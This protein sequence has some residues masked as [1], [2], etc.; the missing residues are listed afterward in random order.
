MSSPTLA[1][2]DLTDLD[3]FADGFPHHLFEIDRRARAGAGSGWRPA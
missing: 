3:N 1:A 2:I